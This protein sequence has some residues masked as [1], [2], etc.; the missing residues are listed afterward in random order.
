MIT[1]IGVEAAEDESDD[2]LTIEFWEPDPAIS[3]F[4]VKPGSK[5]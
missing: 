2:W 5:R 1:R 4:A 3:P